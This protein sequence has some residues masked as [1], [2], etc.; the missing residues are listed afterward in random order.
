MVFS[1]LP[2]LCIF[3]PAVLLLYY[4]SK[5]LT[6]KNVILVIASLLF[7]A[8]GEPVYI[9][10]L[11]FTGLFNYVIG[12]SIHK[13][14]GTKQAS[15]ALVFSI[16]V[17]LGLL[18]VFKY[19]DFFIQNINALLDT[20]IPFANLGLPL[21]IS[22]FTFQTMTYAIDLYRGKAGVQTS[23]LK[24]MVYVTMFPQLLSG[25]IVRYADI[26]A[27]LDKRSVTAEDFT[28]G[29][30]C[31]IRGLF[32]KNV[33][34]NGAGQVVAT[35]L[36]GDLTTLSVVG[37]WLGIIMYTFQIYYDF[38]GY[39]DMAIGLA[40]FFGFKFKKNFDYPYISTSATEFWRRWHISLGSYFRD[41]VYIPLGGNRSHHI[42]NIFVVWLLTGLWHGASWNFILWGLYYAVFLLIEKKCFGGKLLSMPRLLGT[43]YSSILVVFG[44]T[45]FY[46]TDFSRL[47]QFI[48]TAFGGSGIFIDLATKGELYG[49]LFLLILLTLCAT[50]VFKI[51][52]EKAKEK[53]PVLYQIGAPVWICA[54]MLL[55]FTL[56]IGQTFTPFLYFKF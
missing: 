17:N 26:E 2:F 45:L 6:Y 29:I 49:N 4:T 39:S 50:P 16:V 15:F 32:K 48:K 54:V 28:E 34:A 7:Y 1:S 11:I 22:F 27:Q 8:W 43:I 31:F 52:A 33:L 55:C 47:L 53:V 38:S 23:L 12:L 21:G 40:R 25:P 30:F 42:R 36:E 37:A 13:H 56:L 9:V 41:Y 3:L 35:F 14:Q 5:N 51:L 44:W 20:S 46:F 10:G 18:A 24:F 19:T